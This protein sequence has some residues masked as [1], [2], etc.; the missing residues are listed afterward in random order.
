MSLWQL[1]REDFATVKR[2]D[3][4]LKSKFELFFNYPGVWA[5]FF[6]RIAH[7]LYSKEFKRLARFISAMGQFLT[8]VDI[9]PGARIGRRV[10]IDHATGVVIGETAIVGNDVLIYQQVTLGGV[11]LSR[12]KRH[13][14][15]EDGVII[16]AGAKVLGNI[17]IGRESKVGAN[18]VVI[19]DVPPG[20]TAV[21][22]P[23]RI[24][25]RVDNKAPLS[26]NVMPDVNREVFEYLLKRIAV[27]EH[28]IK[29]G[30][31]ETM[32]KQ[33]HELDEVYKNFIEAMK[34]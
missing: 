20:C 33:D 19:R 30:D 10:F 4:A 12:G 32:E 28:T 34:R 11:S 29:S 7:S 21:G 15:V 1:I 26:H 9:H 13:P 2:N 3:P 31:L 17:T 27:L 8:A 5:L 14:T 18:S 16:G 23:A 25:Q 22:V 6:Y 24:A